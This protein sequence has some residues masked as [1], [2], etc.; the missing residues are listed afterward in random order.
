MNTLE[1][2]R[3]LQERTGYTPL[4]IFTTRTK[5]KLPAAVWREIAVTER[6]WS[7]ADAGA[8]FVD[9]GGENVAVLSARHYTT[10]IERVHELERWL[11][12]L[13][14]AGETS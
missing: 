6:P 7:G 3:K 5:A 13:L 8:V 11:G 1:Q 10:I 12:E 9:D 4:E 14:E 2:Q